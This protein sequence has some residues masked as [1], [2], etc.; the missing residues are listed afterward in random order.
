MDETGAELPQVNNTQEKPQ[1]KLGKFF[2]D[3]RRPFGGGKKPEASAPQPKTEE[4]LLT[5]RGNHQAHLD[6]INAWNKQETPHPADKVVKDE[7]NS[8]IEGIDAELRKIQEAKLPTPPTI[9]EIPV[10]TPIAEQPTAIPVAP[11]EKPPVSIPVEEP[12]AA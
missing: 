12:A 3:L 2:A 5:E 4:Q 7:I 8:K 1:S 11:S 10:K 9:A 6:S